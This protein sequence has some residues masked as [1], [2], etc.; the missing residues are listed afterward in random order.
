MGVTDSSGGLHQCGPVA[1]VLLVLPSSARS[2]GAEGDAG[3]A[4][5]VS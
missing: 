3:S 1:G 2:L 5:K 4:R